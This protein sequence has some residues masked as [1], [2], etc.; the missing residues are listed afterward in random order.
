MPGFFEH[1]EIWRNQVLAGIVAGALC[2]YLGVWVV[3]RRVVFVAA[4]LGEVA[5]LGVVVAFLLA[6]QIAAPER[7]TVPDVA[8]LPA[9]ATRV[10]SAPGPAGPG[11]HPAAAPR[12]SDVVS[13]DDLTALLSNVGVSGAGTAVGTGPGP[14][15]A[16]DSIRDSGQ[17]G[18]AD[19]ASP[20]AGPPPS[21]VFGANG[22]RP[23]VPPAGAAARD[24]A[25]GGEDELRVP[26][27]LQPMV[28]AIVF[29][30]LAAV[31]LSLAPRYR[32][33][34]NESVV[35]LAYLVAAGLVILIGSRI[36]QG[37]HEVSHV[38]YGDSVSLDPGQLYGLLGAAAA[39]ALLHLVLFK[40]F[41][42]VSYDPETAQASGIPTRVM[43]ILL[44]VSIGIVIASASRAVG[45]LPVFAFLVLPPVAALLCSSSLRACLALSAAFGAAA[46]VL[47]YYL[48]WTWSFP[49]GAARAVTAA[50]FV[51][52]AL[53]VRL[54]RGR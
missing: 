7:R 49:A 46:S 11:S 48:A 41:L 47:G 34:T 45:A 26:L 53:F 28:I 52:P 27:W 15:D 8:T 22:V 35:G 20:G 19:L 6:I 54:L 5:G 29:V 30:V 10:A 2:G 21:A 51:V 40:E 25:A 31:L 38:L 18:E 14:A 9:P 37:T 4:A 39:V 1:S 32:R 33:V 12:P 17:P 44:L 23:Y 16:G 43:G 3:L 42:F 36:P 50:A 13:D 24:A